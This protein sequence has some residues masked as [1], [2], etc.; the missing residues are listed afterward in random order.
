VAVHPDF[1]SNGWVYVHYTTPSGGTHNRISRF[2]ASGDVAGGAEQVLV[3]L[4]A[5]SSATN[6]NGGAL[7]FGIDGKLYVAVGDNANSAKAP[8][9]AD[10]MGK[11]LR[12]NDDGSIP[13]DNPNSAT[14]SG[15]ARAVWASGLRNPFTFAVQPGSG[16]I[17][18]NDVGQSSWE[19]VNL[20]APG[21]DYGWPASEGPDLIGPGITAP[22]FAY[23]HS[24]TSPPGTGPGGFF[25]CF[26]IAGGAFYP[27]AGP[28]PA[29]YR[30][31]YYFADYGSGFVAR[32]D[33]AHANAVYSFARGF[34]SPVDL[35]VGADGALYVLT[36]SAIAR[37][38]SP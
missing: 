33:L 4:P 17:H 11:L 8:N 26:A 27:A 25:T 18:I 16:R 22:L 1:A 21:A 2:V 19:E 12:F 24:A 31:S 30:G 14:Q 32:M 20:G 23:R 10:P 3:E 15:L 28:F 34:V 7:H 35:R 38:S 36:R 6:H 37:I 29:P 9:P 13:S 5:L